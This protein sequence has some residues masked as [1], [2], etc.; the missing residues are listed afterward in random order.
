M[1]LEVADAVSDG[2]LPYLGSLMNLA[3]LSLSWIGVSTGD[4]DELIEMI[5]VGDVFGAKITGA[6]GGGSVI[7]LPKPEKAES[8]LQQILARY[9]SSFITSIPQE[10]LRWEN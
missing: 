4:L 10:G 2:D 1:S 6:G 7:A 5:L 9:K 8:L 3:Q